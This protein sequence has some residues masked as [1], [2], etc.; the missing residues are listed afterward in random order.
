MTVQIDWISACV[1][2]PLLYQTGVQLYDTGRV[3]VLE[4]GGKVSR[5]KADR[6]M[7]EGSFDNR[8]SVQSHDGSSLWI[9]GNPVKFFQGHNLFGSQDAEGLFLATGLHVRQSAGLFPGPETWKASDY[10]RPRFSRVDL[11]RSYRFPTD[12]AA[13]V[14][15][16]AAAAGRSRH[17]AAV[18]RGGTVYWGMNSRRWT[19]KAYLKS[20]ELQAKGKMHRLAARLLD[21]DHRALSEWARG[22]VRFEL[23]LRGMEIRDKRLDLF[24]RSGQGLEVWESYFG[25][26]TLNRNAQAIGEPDMLQAALPSHLAGYLARWKTGEDLRQ[27]LSKATFYRVRGELLKV[28]GVDI[29]SP[30]EAFDAPQRMDLAPEGWDPEPIR[31]LMFEPDQDIKRQYGL[32]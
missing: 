19:L 31:E 13:R 27:G 24:L 25:S 2:S 5:V 22:V 6:F 20:D 21:P 14:W 16:R 4:P 9:S 18:V 11:T 29:A 30:P 3:V 15:L 26:I 32:I 17:G 8:I 1:T 28:A 12:E 7:V 23:T 10:E